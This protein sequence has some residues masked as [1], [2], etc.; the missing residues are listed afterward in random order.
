MTATQKVWCS[1]KGPQCSS[2][3]PSCAL[4]DVIVRPRRHCDRRRRSVCQHHQ[5]CDDRLRGA[6]MEDAVDNSVGLSCSR[7]MMKTYFVSGG[8]VYA[9]SLPVS[10]DDLRWEP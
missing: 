8:A 5:R 4:P 7:V 6:V 9:C 10:A 1:L 3:A 2:E